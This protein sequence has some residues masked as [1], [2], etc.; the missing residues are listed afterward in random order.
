MRTACAGGAQG[1]CM[2]GLDWRT[3]KAGLVQT[4]EPSNYTTEFE[5]SVL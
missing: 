5:L 1:V 2:A 4:K 3:R